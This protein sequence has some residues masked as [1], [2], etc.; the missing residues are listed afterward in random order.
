[1]SRGACGSVAR[2]VTILGAALGLTIVGVLPARA[3]A[4]RAEFP[5]FT[6]P[7]V[8]EA[9]VVPDSVER[10]VGTALEDYRR[11]SG[12]QVAVAVVRTT[13]DRSL[14][15]YTID[16]ARDWGVGS[17]GRDNGVV[18]VIAVRDRRLRIEV[19]RGVEDVL[20]DLE[21]GRIIDERLVPLL[22]DGRYGD[23]VRQGS[24]AIRS[25]L[26]DRRVGTLP[27]PPEPEP[28][29]GTV[30]PGA[31]LLPLLLVVLAVASLF[32][33]RGRRRRWAG[34]GA[35]IVW[36]GLGGFGRGGLGG[37][38]GGGGGGGFGGGGGGDFGGGGASGGW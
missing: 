16:L 23:A 2:A 15:D 22:A 38:F 34:L 14:E 6:A 8:D 24:D 26:G 36:G 29:T 35:P 7:V 27:P 28:E 32:G 20:T 30:G 12:R 9:D 1:V 21:A 37:G 25:A 4:P 31:L 3:Q 5:E 10:S 13:G 17:E 11:R 18:L 33:R 19:G